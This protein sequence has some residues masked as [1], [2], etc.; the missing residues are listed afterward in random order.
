LG[1]TSFHRVGTKLVNRLW[2]RALALARSE[3][4]GQTKASPVVIEELDLQGH[5]A[6]YQASPGSPAIGPWGLQAIATSIAASHRLDPAA[7][8][9][10][11]THSHTAPDTLGIWGG[12]D[13][14]YFRG[15]ERACEKAATEA[16]A[17]MR[18]AWLVRGTAS[19][20][21]LVY[22]PTPATSASVGHDDIWPVDETLEV[23]QARSRATGAPL[24]TVFEV[25]VHPDIMEDT[26]FVSPDWPAWAISAFEGKVG[27]H[28]LFIPGLLGSEPVIPPGPHDARAEQR[29]A[30]SYGK[31]I[32]RAAMEALAHARPITGDALRAVR[33]PV[34]IKAHNPQL[35]F[36]S[37][38]VLDPTLEESLG[39]GHILRAIA[40]P[41]LDPATSTVGTF[42]GAVRIGDGMILELPGEVYY[43]V[44]A[45][46]A[47]QVR[48]A[49]IIPDGMAMDQVGYVVM[50]AEWPVVEAENGQGEP[51][52]EFGLGPDA[53]R[54]IVDGALK[55]AAILGFQ[56]AP[57]PG[58]DVAG[59]ADPIEAQLAQCRQLGVCKGQG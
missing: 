46:I 43:D 4:M 21:G 52:V 41:Y 31:R 49:W 58:G 14:R 39:V 28:A 29:L 26:Q 13:L 34:E 47:S 56:V 2:V 12:T 38:H 35:L 10:A 54:S 59:P 44:M 19:I 9:L 5:F 20:K 51:N 40:P 55:A 42:V 18:P 48:T 17:S 32:Y 6:A 22:N 57:R 53:G 16:L 33:V 27:G 3:P 30:A 37:T 45:A 25:G 1:G 7:V 36:L 8:V 24:V 11:S 23:L 50:P 15:I